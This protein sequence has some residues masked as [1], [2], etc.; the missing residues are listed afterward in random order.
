MKLCLFLKKI[1]FFLVHI[2]GKWGNQILPI[3]YDISIPS[4][5]YAWN[6]KIHNISRI[7]FFHSFQSKL[8]NEKHSVT[9]FSFG[10]VLNAFVVRQMHFP[11]VRVCWQTSWPQTAL[12]FWSKYLYQQHWGNMDDFMS[13]PRSLFYVDFLFHISEYLLNIISSSD[14]L[15]FTFKLLL[16]RLS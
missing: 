3:L 7:N 6:N 8:Y 12:T 14:I 10:F 16:F 2:L 4:H 15:L 9:A 1:L 13:Y 11:I 5:Q